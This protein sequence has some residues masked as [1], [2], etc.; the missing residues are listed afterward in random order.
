MD[1]AQDKLD[2]VLTKLRKQTEQPDQ[3]ILTNVD[4]DYSFEKTLLLLDKAPGV[5]NFLKDVPEEMQLMYESI[6]ELATY[7]AEQIFGKEGVQLVSPGFEEGAA[8]WLENV[9]RLEFEPMSLV[10]NE[11]IMT[12]VPLPQEEQSD[13]GTL[14]QRVSKL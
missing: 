10:S 13:L 5:A 1:S 6:Y 2:T 4:I 3:V 7:L 8:K 14:N 12:D 9:R 11:D